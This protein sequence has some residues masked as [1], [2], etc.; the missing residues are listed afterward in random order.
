MLLNAL[1]KCASRMRIRLSQALSHEVLSLFL[2]LSSF[3]S[4]TLPLY[5]SLSL[6]LWLFLITRSSPTL[7]ISLHFMGPAVDRAQQLNCIATELR[8][9]AGPRY[10]I[11]IWSSSSH[12]WRQHVILHARFDPHVCT[13]QLWNV[14]PIYDIVAIYESWGQWVL[15]SLLG[16]TLA[17]KKLGI[18]LF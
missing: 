10:S 6:S 1:A 2:C 9:R 14:E 11:Q 18:Y 15:E 17:S 8:V 12:V 5:H 4:L 13:H 7:F 3:I 16:K